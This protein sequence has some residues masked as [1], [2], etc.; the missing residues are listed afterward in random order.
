MNRKLI[1]SILALILVVVMVLSLVVS[2]IPID[3][4]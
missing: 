3:P 1:I 4:S 2:A